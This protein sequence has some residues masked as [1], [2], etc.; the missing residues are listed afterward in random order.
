M[1]GN[2]HIEFGLNLLSITTTRKGEEIATAI[3][4]LGRM[5][6][7]T[8]KRQTIEQ[9]P[10]SETDDICKLGDYVYSKTAVESYGFIIKT[11]TWDDVTLPS[12]LLNK[13]VSCLGK[14]RLL[15]GADSERHGHE[16]S[17]LRRSTLSMNITPR[18]T[19]C[20]R[21]ISSKSS[22]GASRIPQG[23]S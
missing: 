22:A 18:R 13:A 11:K 19:V 16:G 15:H 6:E 23:T 14:E 1:L 12:N 10:D 21:A 2:Q 3:L 17:G 8:Q 9:L 5:D 7:E 20:S 4:P